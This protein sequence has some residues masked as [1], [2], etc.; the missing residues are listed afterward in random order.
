[1]QQAGGLRPRGH[2]YSGHG[3]DA[4]LGIDGGRGDWTGDCSEAMLIEI[5]RHV[6]TGYYVP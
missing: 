1:M 6:W 5:G 3:C 2:C 4:A